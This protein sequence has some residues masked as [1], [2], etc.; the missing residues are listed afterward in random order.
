MQRHARKSNSNATRSRLP[1]T[2]RGHSRLRSPKM[3]LLKR[4][5]CKLRQGNQVLDLPSHCL[6]LEGV[7]RSKRKKS[8]RKNWL[9]LRHSLSIKSPLHLGA[10]R[11]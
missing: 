2:K 5:R 6:D 4:R 10:C 1:L 7:H 3:K 11:H 9:L 8:K